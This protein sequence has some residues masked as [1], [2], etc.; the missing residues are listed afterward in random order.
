MEM[1]AWGLM[2]GLWLIA[3]KDAA[4]AVSIKRMR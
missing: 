1:F 4:L 3:L 2:A